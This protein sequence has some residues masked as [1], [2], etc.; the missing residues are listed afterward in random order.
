[1]ITPLLAI[2]IVIGANLAVS[3]CRPSEQARAEWRRRHLFLWTTL[4]AI[5]LITLFIAGSYVLRDVW[6]FVRSI[7]R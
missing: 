5:Q 3:R 1:M 7:F 4:H 6:V 2:G